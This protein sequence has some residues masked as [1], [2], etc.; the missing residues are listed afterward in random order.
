M[1]QRSD[2]I[3]RTERE[4]KYFCY[5]GLTVTKTQGP[6]RRLG[7]CRATTFVARDRADGCDSAAR[8]TARGENPAPGEAA[9]RYSGRLLDRYIGMH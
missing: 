9:S 8:R 4:H 7:P 3:L 6:S 1:R 2:R 5:E